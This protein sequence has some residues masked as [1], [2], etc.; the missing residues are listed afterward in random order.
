MRELSTQPIILGEI[1][2]ENEVMVLK[3][4]MEPKEFQTESQSARGAAAQD[5]I[6]S[7]LC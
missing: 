5:L 2:S 7:A 1:P 6:F 3:L 4:Q